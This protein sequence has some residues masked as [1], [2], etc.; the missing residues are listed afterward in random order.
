VADARVRLVAG[1]LGATKGAVD[2]IDIAPTLLDAAL[3]AGATFRHDLPGGDAAFV[4]VL[5]GTVAVGPRAV[6]V[7][8]GHLA[9][10]G[11]GTTI[12]ATTETGGRFLLVAGTPIREP[13]ARRGP[14]VMNTDE[15]LRQA[16]DDYRSGRLTL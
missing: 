6:A 16:F 9:V 10:L 1:K 12:T 14:F 7:S 8:A 4:Y 13:V 3:Q 5:D 15:E 11:S 2:G